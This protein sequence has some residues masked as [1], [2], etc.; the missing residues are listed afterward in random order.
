MTVAELMQKIDGALCTARTP[1]DREIL[2]GCVCDLLSYVMA[3]A[4]QGA[5]WVTVQTHMNVVAVA[6]LLDLACVILPEGMT[7]EKAM[8]EKAEETGL[9]I[10]SSGKN[11]FDIVGILCAHNVRGA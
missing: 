2:S 11:A 7:P 6:E 4:K 10:I 5:A 3:H 1:V 8:L 9:P